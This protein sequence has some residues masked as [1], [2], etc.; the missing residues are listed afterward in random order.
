MQERKIKIYNE[1]FLQICS[2]QY[3]AEKFDVTTKTIENTIKNCDDIVYSKKLGAY[4]FKDLMPFYISYQNYFDLF[5]ENLANPILKKDMIKSI[6]SLEEDLNSIMV[7]TE[8]LSEL[9]KKIIRANIAINHQCIIKIDYPREGTPQQDKYIKPKQIITFDAIY[10][11]TFEYDKKNKTK[12]LEERP[13]A[14]NGIH[15][16]EEVEYL[17]DAESF[18]TNHIGNS[19]GTVDE[20]DKK[21]TLKLHGHA[22]YFFMRE[23]LFES[24]YYKFIKADSRGN[25]LT[26]EMI[27]NDEIEVSKLV[28]QWMPLIFVVN[29]SADAQKVIER[30][31]RNY[32]E[33][34]DAK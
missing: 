10:Y 17:K 33:F 5:K 12:G 6:G 24:P 34:L 1:L 19:F 31:K 3:L 28:Q 11:L 22:S 30:I 23:G 20:A 27:Y 21:V 8:L 2:K 29:D 13:F 9:S 14:F 32:N 26:M 4:H 25:R 18:R 16:I 15:S 7:E